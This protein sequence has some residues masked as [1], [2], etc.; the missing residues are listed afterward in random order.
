MIGGTDDPSLRADLAKS[1]MN[2]VVLPDEDTVQI[3]PVPDLPRGGCA[4][5]LSSRERSREPAR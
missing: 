5:S 4:A 3:E 1:I 2:G